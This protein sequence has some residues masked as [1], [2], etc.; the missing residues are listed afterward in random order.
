MIP[1]DSTEISALSGKELSHSSELNKFGA[2]KIVWFHGY[3]YQ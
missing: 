1:L 2:D 3:W